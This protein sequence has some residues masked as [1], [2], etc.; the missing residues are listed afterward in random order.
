MAKVV[1]LEDWR[2]QHKQPGGVVWELSFERHDTGTDP[3]D[4]G[5]ELVEQQCERLI[6]LGNL[7]A[8]LMADSIALM[9]WMRGDD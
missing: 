7:L 4:A 8:E 9:N 5:L 1:K 3:Q 6:A 2:R